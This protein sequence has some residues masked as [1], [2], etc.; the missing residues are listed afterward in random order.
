MVDDHGLSCAEACRTVKLARSAFYK[1]VVDRLRK[2]AAVVDAL[3][4]IVSKRTR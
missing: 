3:N 4:E 1:P 2:D